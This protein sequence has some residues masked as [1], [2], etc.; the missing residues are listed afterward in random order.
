MNNLKKEI[1][2]KSEVNNIYVKFMNKYFFYDISNY[3]VYM[4][5][6]YSNRMSRL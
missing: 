5:Y 4:D 6:V 2:T 3:T 1:K